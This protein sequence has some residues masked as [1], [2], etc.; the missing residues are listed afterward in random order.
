MLF[1]AITQN[2]TNTNSTLT[3]IS[4]Q[5][6]MRWTLAHRFA[7]ETSSV[8]ALHLWGHFVRRLTNMCKSMAKFVYVCC[9]SFNLAY[10]LPYIWTLGRSPFVLLKTFPF[11]TCNNHVWERL[12][13]ATSMAVLWILN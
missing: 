7:H 5:Y 8:Y 1:C 12:R 11:H 6:F 3:P 10:A 2:K 13:K 4:F 9:C